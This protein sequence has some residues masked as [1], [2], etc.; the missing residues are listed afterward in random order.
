[1]APRKAVYATGDF[2]VNAFLSVLGIVYITYF[3]TQVVGMR[4]ELAGAVQLVGRAIDAFADP[5]MGR[6][7]D[8]CRWKAG[9]RRPFFLLG[10]LP[11]GLFFALLWVDLTGASQLQLF[12]YY[13]AVYVLGCLAMTVLSV[14]YLALLPEMAIG[15]DARTSLN[16]WRNGGA[17]LGVF[18]AVAF[19]PVAN[20]LGGGT[21]GYATAGV[22]FGVLL[23]APWLAIHRVSWERSD[24]QQ[25]E[26]QVSFADGMRILM[27]HASFRRLTAMYLS[28]RVSMDLIGA[29]LIL[30]FTHYIG[31][32]AD[33][34]PMMFFFL[35]SVLAVLPFWLLL[36]RRLEKA[37]IFTLGTLWWAVMQLALW[38]ATPEWPRAWIFA[39][40][41][42]IAAGYAVVD[43]MPWSMIGEVVD[44]DELATGERREGLFNG[45]F[46]FVRKLA[47]TA[48]V[49]FALF[50][51]GQLG[52]HQ[53]ET[54][55]PA[56]VA[57]IRWLASIVPALLLLLSA[58]FAR[59]YPLTRAE[60]ARILAR[61]AERGDQPKVA[62]SASSISART[63]G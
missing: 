53:G 4:P 52:Y 14:P 25:R 9:R 24:F 12:A 56:A 19:R 50:V 26:A 58:W 8:R 57:A 6:I 62:T 48:G 45:F 28:G 10:A 38:F 46:M 44:E 47:G 30:Y 32:T 36:A 21:A 49:A 2:T 17:V 61:L 1:M 59:G 40:A 35:S 22:C 13:T 39:F 16:T 43:L 42:L 7:S 5:L 37:T 41:P 15:Y 51:L 34:E 23:A 60:H 20:A 33:F 27:G 63:A 11:F 3:L 31:R 55:P 54:Q 18:A 29:M